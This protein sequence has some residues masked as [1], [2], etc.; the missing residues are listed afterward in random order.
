[1]ASKDFEKTTKY[2]SEIGW[3]RGQAW[4][5]LWL[6]L[7]WVAMAFPANAQ[8]Q[9]FITFVVPG[10]PC[11][12]SFSV[13]TDPVA[14]NP[15]GTVTGMY[16]DANGALHGFLRSPEGTIKTFDAPGAACPGANSVCTEP[17]GI[18]PEGAIAGYYCDAVTCHG[19]LRAPD[20]TVTGFDPPGS[21]YTF[22]PWGGINP[23][24]VI[25]GS[26]FDANFL[27][28]GFLR[29]WN[30]TFASIDAPGAANGTFPTAISLA[31]VVAGI[32]VDASF[33]YHGFL[34]A[35]DGNITTFDPKGSTSTTT[36]GINAAGV[37]SGYYTN[38]GSNGFVS[39]PHGFLRSRDGTITV[40]DPPGA[41]QTYVSGIDQAGAA[42]GWFFDGTT[43][44]GA[45]VSH[46]FLRA[47][48]GSFTVFDPP[49]KPAG[50]LTEATAINAEGVITGWYG[51]G[52]TI[53]GYLRIP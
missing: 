23:A 17:K 24:G 13:C 53:L 46:N 19:F 20:G 48:D 34:R 14:I 41:T 22:A 26:Y 36:T 44:N 50:A 7:C 45:P 29:A 35:P 16:P 47:H 33:V 3:R 5:A 51:N 42:A 49:G 43:S 15:R 21:V 25:T 27:G 38:V 40:F 8:W 28:H 52:T 18:N 12:N 4:L 9:K 6:A 11:E 31:G 2:G 39:G 10:S 32:Y 1:M 37:V 30:G